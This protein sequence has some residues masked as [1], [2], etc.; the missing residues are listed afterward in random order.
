M[1]KL[2]AV[3]DKEIIKVLFKIGF[4]Y[5]PRRGKGSHQAF[6]KVDANYRKYLVIVPKCKEM[7]A[8]TL[9]CIM[10][11]AGISR[12]EFIKLLKV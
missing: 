12:D 7:P 1:A 11:Q 9:L 4:K 10:E 2:P 3:S 8:G 6:I 5:A